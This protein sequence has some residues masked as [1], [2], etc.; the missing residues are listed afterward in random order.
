MPLFFT[1]FAVIAFTGFVTAVIWSYF[2]LSPQ[3]PVNIRT[4]SFFVGCVFIGIACGLQFIKGIFG[5]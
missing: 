3:H 2:F 4:A 5:K 1:A